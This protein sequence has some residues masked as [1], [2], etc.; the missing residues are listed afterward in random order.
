MPLGG[1]ATGA[2][3][4]TDAAPKVLLSRAVRA[5]GCAASASRAGAF[6]APSAIPA[7]LQSGRRIAVIRLPS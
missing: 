5:D 2:G 3:D 1:Y 7:A 6:A 4:I